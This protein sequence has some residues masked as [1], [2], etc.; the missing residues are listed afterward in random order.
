[1]ARIFINYRRSD[2][3]IYA[4]SLY[5]WLAEHYGDDQ[6]FKDVDTI[7][8]GLPWEE[9]IERAVAAADV[10]LV[11]IGPHWLAD[12]SGRR[13]LEDPRDY[14]HMEIAKALE[15]K[16]RVIPILVSGAQPPEPEELPDRLTALT[17]RQAFELSD[18]RMRAD[19]MELLRRLDRVLAGG[20]PT[21]A[22]APAPAPPPPDVAPAP[23][24]PEPPAV[25]PAPAEPE[26]KQKYA[27]FSQRLVAALVDALVFAVPLVVLS[28]ITESSS[29]KAGSIPGVSRIS[30]AVVVPAAWLYSAL[31]ES[32]ARQATLGKGVLGIIVTDLDGKRISFGKAT[33]RYLGKLVSAVLLFIG[34]IVAAFTTRKQALHDM[35]VGTLVVVRD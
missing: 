6:V 32:S 1:V 30:I 35:I 23:A 13:R 19:R 16:I 4:N 31:M 2:S 24:R 17:D 8:P 26:T 18:S 3:Q 5:D 34:F 11:V 20:P 33:A 27:R 9:A 21:P 28:L 22:P 29:D 14:V 15:R 12:Q 10:M 7:E 25:S